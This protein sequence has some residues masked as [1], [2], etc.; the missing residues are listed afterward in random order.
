L[1]VFAS[2]PRARVVNGPSIEPAT[3]YESWGVDATVPAVFAEAA[4]RLP[5]WPTIGSKDGGS[6]GSYTETVQTTGP[7][8]PAQES[9]TISVVSDGE[10]GSTLSVSV[11]VAYRPSKPAA[12]R[13]PHSAV[14]IVSLQPA[15]DATP[16]PVDPVRRVISSAATIAQI[17]DEI[18]A[19][20]ARPVY[21]TYA[22]PAMRGTATL[23][24]EFAPSSAA[25]ASA[26]T[27]V[28]V[29]SLPSGVCSPGVRVTVGGT[30]EPALDD[31][32]HA[33]LF[34]ELERLLGAGG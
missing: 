21:G 22:C 31:S 29:S 24:L 13:V 8:T 18:N 5:H 26:S 10:G 17:A 6:A 19:L 1:G 15:P 28:E 7:G 9:V 25:P 30:V 34:T 27:V 23:S 3:A 20:P 12:E 33:G 11:Q 32:V 14:L 4:A 2:I 16:E